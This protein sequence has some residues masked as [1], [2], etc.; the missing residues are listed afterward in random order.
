MIYRPWLRAALRNQV[1]VRN[2]LPP[3]YWT[4]LSLN[5]SWYP[6]LRVAPPLPLPHWILWIPVRLIATAST[7]DWYGFRDSACLEKS[8]QRHPHVAINI[9]AVEGAVV[10]TSHT[11]WPCWKCHEYQPVLLAEQNNDASTSSESLQ[12]CHCGK[13]CPQWGCHVGVPIF[14]VCDGDARWRPALGFFPVV[15][16]HSRFHV[17]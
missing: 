4:P 16:S 9:L 6:I 8:L 3:V 2:E 13:V 11:G 17:C 12:S 14:L 1:R 10:L 7:Q 15:R 5:Y